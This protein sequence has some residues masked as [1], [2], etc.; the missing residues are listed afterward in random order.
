MCEI[1]ATQIGVFLVK[2]I[3]SSPNFKGLFLLLENRR[4][5]IK[6]S[7]TKYS[8]GRLMDGGKDGS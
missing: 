1:N 4:N 6:P 8:S 5:W 2:I 3:S 7:V